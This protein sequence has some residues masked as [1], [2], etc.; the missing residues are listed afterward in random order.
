[1]LNFVK[2]GKKTKITSQ[3][4][5]KLGFFVDDFCYNMMRKAPGSP[6][7]TTIFVQVVLGVAPFF[8]K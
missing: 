7:G 5:G 3:T 2:C 1:M 8:F 6:S 4:S